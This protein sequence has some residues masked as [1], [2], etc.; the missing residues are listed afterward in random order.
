MIQRMMVAAVLGVVGLSTVSMA[1]AGQ[2]YCNS[3]YECCVDFPNP[4]QALP[5]AENGDGRA[6]R[7]AGSTA[8]IR[9]YASTMPLILDMSAQQ[10]FR[11]SQKEQR[12]K[13]IPDYELLKA[14]RYVFSVREGGQITY[15]FN[16]SFKQTSKDGLMYS[17]YAQ[18]PAAEQKRL[19]PIIQQM[20][21]SLRLLP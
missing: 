12:A 15:V 8:D 21:R 17:V 5:E 13:K 14:D 19:Q 1:K 3:K 16:R 6:F 10:Y 4:M 7:L 18:Y 11:A 9:V 20:T 2:S